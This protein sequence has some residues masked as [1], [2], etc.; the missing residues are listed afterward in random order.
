MRLSAFPL[1]TPFEK[2]IGQ[3]VANWP[4]DILTWKRG[5]DGIPHY[6]EGHLFDDWLFFR[7]KT[8]RDFFAEATRTVREVDPDIV[9]EDNTGMSYGAAR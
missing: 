1:P 8:I 7:A 4:D 9:V 6:T 3:K 5:A 2:T